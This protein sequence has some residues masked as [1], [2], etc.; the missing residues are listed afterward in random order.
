LSVIIRILRSRI[1]IIRTTGDV[2]VGKPLPQIGGKGV[3]TKELE[4]SLVDGRIDIAV[5]SLK[6]LP[7]NLPDGLQIVAVTRREDARDALLVSPHLRGSV[8][9]ITQLPLGASVGT[10]SLRRASQLRFLRPDLRLL[11]IRGNIDTR[12]RKVETGDYDAICLACAGLSRLGLAERI[13]S[14]IETSELL[15]AVGRVLLA[16]KPGLATRA[17]RT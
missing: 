15:P 3:F 7:T 17:S 5:H 13:D 8:R 11:D 2:L 6:D 12:V 4:D 1:E 9:A 16:S 14:I 10:S